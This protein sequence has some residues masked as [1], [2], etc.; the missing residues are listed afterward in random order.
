MVTKRQRKL[1]PSVI[2]PGD[3]VKIVDPRYIVRIGY[4]RSPS[5]YVLDDD[6]NIAVAALIGKCSRYPSQPFDQL[7]E[8]K[9][10]KR[11][12]AELKYLMALADG[13]GG[14][15]REIYLSE[16]LPVDEYDNEYP[17]VLGKE[18]P[19][20]PGKPYQV[21]SLRTKYTGQRDTDSDYNDYDGSYYSWNI[22]CP[23]KC[24]RLATIHMHT[25][26]EF[27]VTHLEKIHDLK[28]YMQDICDKQNEQ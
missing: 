8:N 21:E 15:K 19:Y 20:Y 23:D 5:D 13:F 26:V 7:E 9:Q 3:W 12:T 16:P 22:F 14:D 17:Y 10:F 6:T 1:D 18:G 28:Q 24:Y 11:I 27:P 25:S 2:R 4:P